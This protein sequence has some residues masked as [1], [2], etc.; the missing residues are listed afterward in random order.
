MSDLQGRPEDVIE[1]WTRSGPCKIEL[2]S[3]DLTRLS[4][5]DMVDII[6]VSAFPGDYAAMSGTVIGALKRNLGINVM[7]LSQNKELDLRALFSCWLSKPIEAGTAPYKKLLCFERRMGAPLP[8]PAQIS[9]MFR[10]FVPVF[11]NQDHTVITPLLATG[12]QGYD[13]TMVCGTMVEAAVKW[14]NAGLPLRKFKIVIYEGISKDVET[15][16]TALKK[17]YM[18]KNEKM[19]SRI[20]TKQF[21]VFV[22][23]NPKDQVYMQKVKQNLEEKK[24]D[25]KLYVNNTHFNKNKVWQD[26]IFKIMVA[27]K[28]VVAILSPAFMESSECLEQYNMAMCCNRLLGID[29]LAPL[30]VD[31]INSLPSYMGLVQWI[32]CRVRKESD[33]TDG[34]IQ[35][36]CGNIILAIEQHGDNKTPM[37]PSA[38]TNNEQQNDKF[39]FDVFISYSHKNPVHA[40]TLL[41]TFNKIDPDLKVFYDRSALTTGTNWQN[42]LYQSV[43]ECR[44][45]IALLSSTYLSST[46]CMEEFNL[47]LARYL[48]KDKDLMLIPVCIEE[49]KN[50][51]SHISTVQMTEAFTDFNQS[52][53]QLATSVVEWLKL[54]SEKRPS[55][56]TV[57]DAVDI[58]SIISAQRSEDVRQQYRLVTNKEEKR[59]ERIKPVVIPSED[60]D[61]IRSNLKRCTSHAV[62]KV[63]F[64][65]T[66]RKIVIFVSQ[67]FLRNENH[68]QELHLALNRQRPLME[69]VLY[70]ILT[71]PLTGRPFFPRILPYNVSCTDTIWKELEKDFIGKTHDHDVTKVAVFGKRRILEHATT[72]FC[73]RAEYFAM[74]KAVDDVLESFL[75][76]RDEKQKLGPMLL[77]VKAIENM[78]DSAIESSM[79]VTTGHTSKSESEVKVENNKQSE[80]NTA[81]NVRNEPSTKTNPSEKGEK[82]HS[83]VNNLTNNTDNDV[84]S[85]ENKFELKRDQISP[86]PTGLK[87]T[88]KVDKSA[89]NGGSRPS[90]GTS[91]SCILL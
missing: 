80:N 74:T 41:E 15:M 45:F 19:K 26:G 33:T 39:E 4:R 29:V 37:P 34:K 23:F 35:S 47:A 52:A 8:V 7:Q 53:S 85:K 69:N 13:K 24:T 36:A 11:N 70:L 16:F 21:D 72:F 50:V 91:K 77:N 64:P 57:Q 67:D 65:F 59:F 75:K 86:S 31:T 48:C 81:G 68:M 71:T 73:R 76:Q 40:E 78:S 55:M 61:E 90:K 18:A 46:V 51:P 12:H 79:R 2:L 9:E 82:E 83:S 63:C 30:Y 32:D 88:E 54:T 60:I 58:G 62:R 17:K 14:I 27:C 6:I 25:I 43:G 22:M 38:D 3:G 84:K 5:D 56:Y 1:L 42:M 44:C 10:V 66:A 28:R 89:E 87:S 49:L 20:F